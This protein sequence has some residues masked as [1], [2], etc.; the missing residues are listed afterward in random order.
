MPLPD[1]TRLDQPTLIF[2]GVTTRGSTI[3]RLFP[4]WAETLALGEARLAGVDLPPDSPPEAYDRVVRAIAEEPMAR[5]ALVTT[6]KIAVWRHAGR[7]FAELD[8]WARVLGEIGCIAKDAEGRLIGKAMDPVTAGKAL[9]AIVERAHWTRHDRAE[10]L[11]MGA[12]GAGV[13]LAAHLLERPPGERPAKIAIT[14]VDVG[15][16]SSAL[17][18]LEP[19]DTDR[20]MVYRPVSGAG[21][22]DALMQEL[23]RGSL[24]ANATGLGKDR[25]GSP[26][27]A[28]ARFPSR[29]IAWEF[30]YR[31]ALTFLEQA[32]GKAA[33]SNLIVADGWRYFL[34]GW[35][36]VIAAVF[37]LTLDPATVARLEAAAEPLRP[38]ATP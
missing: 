16:L 21:D 13:G 27:T 25:P 10:A 18:H 8:R 37:G 3:N 32:R 1:G 31:G 6:H 2:I 23:P 36:T 12:G 28:A 34:Y 29:G 7:R 33:S 15:R 22:H 30:N 19:L 5:G 4:L 17:E 14:D 38:A 35:S 20:L 9:D 11:I 24:V 26:V